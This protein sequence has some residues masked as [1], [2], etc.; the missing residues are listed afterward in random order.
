[1]RYVLT[2]KFLSEP[3][4]VVFK[5]RSSSEIS[6]T[7]WRTTVGFKLAGEPGRSHFG[8]SFQQPAP[9]G[10]R[11]APT[12]PAF[13]PSLLPSRGVRRWDS[14]RSFVERND[15]I[16]A[17]G[18][19][20]HMQCAASPPTHHPSDRPVNSHLRR[21]SPGYTRLCNGRVDGS[22]CTPSTVAI[23]LLIQVLIVML[24]RKA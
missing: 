17:V 18:R 2:Y 8:S 3:T 13:E 24:Q 19:I 6:S 22:S 9:L 15:T 12:K 23:A 16:L 20:S 14:R 1:V 4:V 21:G 11:D 10:E 7:A 5:R